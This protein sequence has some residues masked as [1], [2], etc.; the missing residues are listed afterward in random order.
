MAYQYV[1]DLG[2]IDAELEQLAQQYLEGV[3][4][5]LP[6]GVAADIAV[7]RGVP[8]ATLADYLQENAVDLVVM[9]THGRGGVRRLALGSTADRLVRLGLPVLLIRAPEQPS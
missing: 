3:L 2:E 7:I 6:A 4:G 8:A 9:T 5:R 1:P